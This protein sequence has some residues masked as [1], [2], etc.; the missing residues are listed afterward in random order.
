MSGSMRYRL[1]VTI[2]TLYRDRRY[3]MKKKLIR[4]MDFSIIV[5]GRDDSI[6]VLSAGKKQS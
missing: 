5:M 3:K 1:G 4:A 6:S 2:D